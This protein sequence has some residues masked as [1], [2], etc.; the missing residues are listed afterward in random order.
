VPSN[1]SLQREGV[2][3]IFVESRR[4]SEREALREMGG[5]SWWGVGKVEPGPEL[6]FLVSAPAQLSAYANHELKVIPTPTQ[7]SAYANHELKN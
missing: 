7:L 5:Y 6:F 3:R 4:E 2:V 1:A